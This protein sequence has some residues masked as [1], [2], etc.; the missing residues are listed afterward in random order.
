MMAQ[1]LKQ[2]EID[3]IKS[4]DVLKQRFI[5]SY[6]LMLDFFGIHLID[7]TV[8]SLKRADNWEERFSHLNRYM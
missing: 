4:S 1:K 3:A 5:T 6:R 8:G 7:E 2:H